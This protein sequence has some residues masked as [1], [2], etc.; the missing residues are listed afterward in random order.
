MQA[1]IASGQE[2][3]KDWKL[4]KTIEY[5]IKELNSTSVDFLSM[6]LALPILN[7]KTLVNISN[8]NC[9]ANPRKIGDGN[10]FFV[11]LFIE[12]MCAILKYF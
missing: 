1:L 6:Y 7:G 8:I 2:H 9:S 10:K 4:N 12:N 5:I 3:S 11:L